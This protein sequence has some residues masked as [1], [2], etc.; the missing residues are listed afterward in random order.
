M[1]F[2]IV[3]VNLL[4][5]F[6]S[7]SCGV[8]SEQETQRPRR[9]IE[10]KAV[11]GGLFRM[12]VT[13]E[14]RSIF[15]HNIVDA[16]AFN[17][18]NQVYQGLVKI[19]QK[20]Q[21][22]VPSIAKSFE[23]SADGRVYTFKLRDDVF[24]HDDSAFLNGIGRQVKADDVVKCFTL[25][26]EPYLYNQ[27]YAYVIDLIRGG[28]IHYDFIRSNPNTPHQLEGVKK[29]SDFEVQIELEFAA[30]TFM[31]I[32]T[33][34]CCWIFPSELLSYGEDVDT[35]CIGTGPFKARTV[36]MNEVFILE[37]NAKYWGKDKMGNELPYLDAIR[38]NFVFS[39]D[40]QL[41]QFMK[42]NLDLLLK[43]PFENIA[44]FEAKSMASGENPPYRIIT[45]RGLRVEY[46]GFQHRSDLFSDVRVRR[47]INYAIDR[48]YIVDNVLKGYGMPATYGFVPPSM[49]LFSADSVEGFAYNPIRAQRM[50]HEAGY[51]GGKGFPVLTLQLN[52]GNQTVLKVAEA[53][54]EMLTR[55]LGITV[56]LSVLP[57]QSHYEQIAQG[58]VAFWR[59]GWIADY[60]DPEN[61]L[62]LFH[63]KLVPEDNEKA[64]YLNTVRF[65]SDLFDKYFESSMGETDPKE[66]MALCLKADQ[67]IM[68]QAAIAPLYYEKWVWLVGGD[69]ENIEVNNMGELDLEE[70]YFNEPFTRKQ[71]S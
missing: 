58:E 61:F 16:S 32:L 60:P 56:E 67:E 64:T 43:V 62:K 26:C 48:N 54:Q 18:M 22:I 70:V 20:T 15:P 7:T 57:R 59:D 63:G 19:D 66:R 23:V 4:L 25:L 68:D 39:E 69:V 13:E 28:R 38:C 44:E 31:T 24:F 52:D 36:K 49:P 41:R 27:N 35:W 71:R 5:I 30:P 34:P 8:T 55:N 50:L 11:Y 33:H 47:A 6:F 42:G 65:K 2:R 3:F 37:R 10:G 1:Y 51:S 53:V 29:I 45:Q 40:E 9:P 21:E 46:Y 12:N 14:M 17:I